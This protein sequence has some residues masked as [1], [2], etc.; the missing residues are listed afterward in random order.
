M[1]RTKRERRTAALYAMTRE[2]AIRGLDNLRQIATH[3]ISDVFE[4]QTAILL[5][6]SKA[7]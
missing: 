6:I 1:Q 7:N 3:H 5:P 2:F 4:S